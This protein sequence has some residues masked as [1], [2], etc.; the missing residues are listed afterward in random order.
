M[1]A[2]EA[3]KAPVWIPAPSMIP[4]PSITT[5]SED[6]TNAVVA[7][8]KRQ[9]DMLMQR[10]DELAER[11]RELLDKLDD[12]KKSPRK[13]PRDVRPDA[14][15]NEQVPPSQLQKCLKKKDFLSQNNNELPQHRRLKK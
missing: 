4:A 5:T 13:S 3:P 1:E 9:N 15:R 6:A 2:K 7:D 11:N 12:K 8:L 10:L 14:T